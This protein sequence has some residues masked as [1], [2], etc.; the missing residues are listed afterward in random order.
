MVHTDQTKPIVKRKLIRLELSRATKQ[1]VVQ[2]KAMF[3][4]MKVMFLVPIVK[5]LL[6]HFLSEIMHNTVTLI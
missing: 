3:A 1:N 5:P 2:S 4:S 6:K